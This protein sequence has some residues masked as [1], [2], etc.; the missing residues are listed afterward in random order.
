M[1][2]L[3]LLTSYNRDKRQLM[4]Q[5]VQNDICIRSLLSN[6]PRGKFVNVQKIQNQN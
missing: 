1:R 4:I 5:E 3:S 2:I 6:A